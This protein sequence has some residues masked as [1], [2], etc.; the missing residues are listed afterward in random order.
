MNPVLR[1]ALLK[2]KQRTPFNQP[3]NFVFP[4]V[5]LKGKKPLALMEVFNR[6][7]KPVIRELGF[8]PPGVA[9]GWHAFRHG[10]GT[11]LWDLTKDKLTVRDLSRHGTTSMTEKYIHGIDPR[12]QEAQ[13]KLV[14]A[15]ILQS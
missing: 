3:G 7:I 8:A 9:Y 10:V 15:I 2:W 11:A 1:D 13:N 5:R 6:S 12:L 14:N 4:S